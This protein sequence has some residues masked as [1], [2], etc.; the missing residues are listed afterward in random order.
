MAEAS[1][2]ARPR[3]PV[4]LLE[5]FWRGRS[6][7]SA[8]AD[9][10]GA[11]A[12]LRQLHQRARTCFT[13]AEAALN[14]RGSG[15]W[16]FAPDLACDLFRQSCHWALAAI[17]LAEED[18]HPDAVWARADRELMIKAAGSAD[19]VERLRPHVVQKAF[20][21]FA[22][23]APAEQK[24]LA[25]ELRG[26]ALRLLTLL[27]EPQRKIDRV[28]RQRF[29]RVGFVLA[30]IAL[31]VAGGILYADHKRDAT[32]IARGKPWR[33]SSEWA[34]CEPARRR[35]GPIVN[36]GLFF[37]TQEDDGPWLEIDLQS[38]QRFSSIRIEN[39]KDCCLDRAIPLVVE[40]SDDREKWRV[41]AT[42]TKPFRNWEQEIAPQTARYVKVRVPRR[43][44]LHLDRV[45]LF[46]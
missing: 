10:V 25:A 12:R 46:P 28:W 20:V 21:H 38:R 9:L 26:L 32:D 44:W 34:K 17:T 22:E 11:P 4:R 15:P 14:P 41:I 31:F 18:L 30:C 3:L 37:H 13:A 35:C 43:S 5:W 36:S 7:R 39:R 19:A 8:R 16:T 6:L 42:R 2:P 24:A 40:V 29:V 33:A 27:E 1:S 45:A 23:L